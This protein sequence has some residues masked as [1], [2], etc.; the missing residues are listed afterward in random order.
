MQ[1]TEKVSLLSNCK[2]L[3]SCAL[4]SLLVGC[5]FALRG[6][7]EIPVEA[8]SL[9]LEI[10]REG[11]SPLRENFES[12]AKQNNLQID[13]NAD[14]QIVVTRID[15]RKITT[16]L[17]ANAEV[18]EYTLRG[19]LIFNIIDGDKQV[20][21]NKLEAFSERTFQYDAN[22]AAASNSREAFLNDELWHD[23][24]QQILRQYAAHFRLK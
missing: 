12:L 6:N 9:W 16:T 4:L 11:N 2:L 14:N 21:A 20:I 22:D 1:F 10:S 13:E 17:D 3:I 8:Q 5:G 15:Y 23:L 19:E 24:S 7:V 18:D